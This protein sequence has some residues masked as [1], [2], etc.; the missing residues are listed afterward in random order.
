LVRR[1]QRATDLLGRLGGEEFGLLLPETALADALTVGERLR[2]EC[3]AQV[4]AVEGV[5]FRITLSGGVAAVNGA[6]KSLDDV[7][8]RADEALYR[9]KEGGRNR[10]EAEK[11]AVERV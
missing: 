10:V 3:A 2:A 4:I 5:E 6:D 7:M 1:V 9:A 8:R 11:V